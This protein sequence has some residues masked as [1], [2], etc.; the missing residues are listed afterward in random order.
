MLSVMFHLNLNEQSQFSLNKNGAREWNGLEVSKDANGWYF[1]AVM[2]SAHVED[3]LLI[4]A[5]LRDHTE[6]I[7]GI[8]YL[9]FGDEK[10]PGIYLQKGAKVVVYKKSNQPV[11]RITFSG[12]IAPIVLM[13]RELRQGKIT[14]TLPLSSPQNAPSYEQLLATASNQAIAVDRLTEQA[15]S[16]RN[17][18]KAA[19]DMILQQGA[20]IAE[21]RKLV[22][23][24]SQK[25]A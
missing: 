13:L 4:D 18:L 15:V 8:D 23:R 12:Q 19:Q 24:T 1:H 16:A 25:T 10:I 22:A 21:L 6:F 17:V 2:E 7:K 14:P 11:Q 5:K 20:E 9:E 3:L